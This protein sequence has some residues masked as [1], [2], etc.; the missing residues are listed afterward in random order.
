M[1]GNLTW[2]Q[3]EIS[4]RW[5]V[6]LLVMVSFWLKLTYLQTSI[7][8]TDEFISMLAIKMVA[9]HGLPMLPSGLFYD[10]GLLYS[11]LT[12]ALV[13]LLTAGLITFDVLAIKW[14][15]WARGYAQAHLFLLL[16]MT[17]LLISSLKQ[18][19]RSGRYLALLF[20]TGA[21]FPIR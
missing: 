2:K 6:L 13:A 19:S 9:L 21:F 16:G 17:W 7:Y 5:L 12:G 20:L 18:P 10:H 1:T 3:K 8:H 15:V 11:I 4:S 14:G